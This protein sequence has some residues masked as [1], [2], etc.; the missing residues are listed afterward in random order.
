MLTTINE[1][2]KKKQEKKRTVALMKS[3]LQDLATEN[4]QIIDQKYDDR[5][6]KKKEVWSEIRKKVS[7]VGHYNRSPM[8]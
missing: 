1:E 8:S 4:S 7:L 2:Q 6:T 3:V 5:V